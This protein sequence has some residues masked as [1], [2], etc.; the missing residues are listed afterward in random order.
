MPSFPDIA[1]DSQVLVC[2]VTHTADFGYIRDAGWYRLPLAHTPPALSADYLAFYQ[3]AAFA[4]ERWAVR[5]LAQVHAVSIALRRELIPNEPNHPRA[6]ARYFRFALGPLLQLPL[7][8]PSRRLRR[9]TFIPTTI[10][11][12]LQARDVVE[13]WQPP[14]GASDWGDLWGAGVNARYRTFR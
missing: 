4:E 5:Y 3:T 9:I 10:G 8:I 11:Q 1:P 14:A 7:A 2:V 13:L 6:G 12:L